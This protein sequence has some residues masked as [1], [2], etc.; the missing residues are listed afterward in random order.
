MC[1]YTLKQQLGSTSLQTQVLCLSSGTGNPHSKHVWVRSWVQLALTAGMTSGLAAGCGPDLAWFLSWQ[2][3]TGPRFGIYGPNLSMPELVL[4]I[5]PFC[6]LLLMCWS[7]SGASFHILHFGS[8]LVQ[9]I[10]SSVAPVLQ[11]C[12]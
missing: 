12:L 8:S 10:T 7:V 3:T 11:C 9:Q 5:P 6:I 4:C 1:L 2:A